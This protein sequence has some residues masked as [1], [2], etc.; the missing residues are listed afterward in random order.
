V[1]LFIFITVEYIQGELPNSRVEIEI[2]LELAKNV[3]P[4]CNLLC[5]I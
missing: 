2:G 1:L 4:F 3:A 5:E